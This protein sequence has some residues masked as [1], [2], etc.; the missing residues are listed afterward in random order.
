MSEGEK[1]LLNRWLMTRLLIIQ[2]SLVSG[3]VMLADR[4]IYQGCK[5]SE[6]VLWYVNCI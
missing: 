5:K 3:G 2:N 4:N 1:I 6:G